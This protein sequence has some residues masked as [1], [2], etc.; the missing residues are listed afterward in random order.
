MKTIGPVVLTIYTENL[1][2]IDLF[3]TEVTPARCRGHHVFP[4]ESG[5]GKGRRND[6]FYIS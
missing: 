1:A 5:H 2:E 3:F 4:L 6:R